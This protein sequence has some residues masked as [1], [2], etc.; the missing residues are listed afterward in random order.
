MGNPLVGVRR[1][2]VAWVGNALNAVKG[3]PCE[4]CRSNAVSLCSHFIGP[5]VARY[6]FIHLP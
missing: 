4:T 5:I 2:H 6:H 1:P 3:M